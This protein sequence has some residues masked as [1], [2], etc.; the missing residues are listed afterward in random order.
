[1]E[2]QAS[3]G[4][5]GEQFDYRIDMFRELFRP[6]VEI[7]KEIH[8]KQE[9]DGHANILPLQS[10]GGWE[11]VYAGDWQY[12]YDGYERPGNEKECAVA[13]GNVKI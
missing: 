12:S 6:M 10:L 1:M 2:A 8:L 11:I 4:I 7:V 9:T 13:R 3:S 5:H